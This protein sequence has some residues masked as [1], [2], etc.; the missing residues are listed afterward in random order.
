LSLA[1]GQNEA[2]LQS[3]A[4]VCDLKNEKDELRQQFE[5]LMEIQKT[6]TCSTSSKESRRPENNFNN[7]EYQG[8]SE[9]ES[10]AQERGRPFHQRKEH[11]AG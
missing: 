8:T 7:R 6:I 1:S 9:R 3:Q 5:E 10:K 4:A 11:V 2:I